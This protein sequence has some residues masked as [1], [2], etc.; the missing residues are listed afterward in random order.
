MKN[1]EKFNFTDQRFERKFVLTGH[2]LKDIESAL[3]LHPAVFSKIYESRF[4]NTLYFDSHNFDCYFSKVNG[5]ADR[6]KVRLRWYGDLNGVIRESRLELKKRSGWIVDKKV[7]PFPVFCSKDLTE[8][9]IVELARK[10]ELPDFLRY[11]VTSLTPVVVTRYHRH[12]YRSHCRNYRITLDSDLEFYKFNHCL[13]G[14]VSWKSASQL[15]V[16]LELKY[17][18]S[19]DRNADV[20]TNHFPFRL[21]KSSKYID[22]MEMI[23]R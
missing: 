18:V 8:S 2:S 17:P 22:G 6:L 3:K 7:F 12:Y 20:I 23:Y 10:A 13:D 1:S 14:L 11:E 16:I 15:N 9:M 4:V 5:A 21:T 19:E